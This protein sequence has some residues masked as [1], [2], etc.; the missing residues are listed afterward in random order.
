M[1]SG[2]CGD[3]AEKINVQKRKKK[4]FSEDQILDWFVQICSA[5]KHVH[6]MDVVHEDLKPQNIFFTDKKTTKLGNF[7]VAKVL[8]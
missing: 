7:G 5:L 2:E 6:D 4:P 8:C 1:E 3:L